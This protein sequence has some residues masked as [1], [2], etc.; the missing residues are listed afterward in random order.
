MLAS[1]S[2]MRPDEELLAAW[3]SGDREAGNALFARHFDSVFGFFRHKIDNTAADLTQQVFLRLLEGGDGL[4]A[5]GHFRGYLFAIARNVLYGELRRRTHGLAVDIEVESLADLQRSP[6]VA[7]AQH[8]DQRLIVHALRR[9]PLMLQVALELYFV[10]RMRGEV[11]AQALGI[12]EGTVRSR[13]RRGIEGLRTAM[14][15]LSASPH[16]VRTTLTDLYRWAEQLRLPRE[17]DDDGAPP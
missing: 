9:L 4:R 6:S 10:Q 17:P 3:R 7:L 1:S 8:Q 11:I 14:Q 16:D 15:D 2:I 13:I 12:P 5:D